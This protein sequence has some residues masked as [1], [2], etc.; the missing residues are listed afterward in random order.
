M[1]KGE[2][3]KLQ[4]VF[5]DMD[6]TLINSEPYWHEAELQVAKENGGY[7]DKDLA[8]SCS[9]TSLTHVAAMMIE[10]GTQLDEQTIIEKI[11]RIVEESEQRLLPWIEGVEDVLISLKEHDIPCVLV[12]T[13]PRVMAQNLYEHAPH[14]SLQTY[15]CGQDV[16]HHKPDPEP[17]L[18]AASKIVITPEQMKHCIIVE[19]SATGLTAAK[20]TGAFVLAQTAY[21]QNTVSADLYNA[22][23]HGYD[24]VD[25]QYLNA[26]LG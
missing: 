6:G 18:L 8:W 21:N 3:V 12:T 15:V 14:N 10:R 9:G 7:W 23:I 25:A 24:G 2:F 20:S 5:W 11:M 16:K 19:D 22:A 17:Y 1:S 26:L 13:S 4:A